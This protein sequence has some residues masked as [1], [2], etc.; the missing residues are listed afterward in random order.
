MKEIKFHEGGMPLNIDDLKLLQENS[1]ATMAAFLKVFAKEKECF[2][3]HRLSATPQ[4][5]S[6]LEAKFIAG[7]LVFNGMFLEI[8]ETTLKV[9]SWQDKIY[10]CV[11]EVEKDERIFEDGQ[12][13]NCRIERQA[14]LSTEKSEALSFD[15]SKLST[16]DELFVE[17]LNL[18]RFEPNWTPIP[19]FFFNGYS[20]KIML[21]RREGST[22]IK[23]QITSSASSW[24][25]GQEGL[26]FE[27]GGNVSVDPIGLGFLDRTCS[28]VFA[29]AGDDVPE[30]AVLRYSDYKCRVEFLKKDTSAVLT[31]N[32][33]SQCSINIIYDLLEQ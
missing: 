24:T 3:L 4:N 5:N 33:P 19:V 14:Y 29:T 31:Q 7:V 30:I 18:K 11:K 1:F 6:L 22:R 12:A 32:S 21:Q 26:L 27:L 9:N 15:T 16:F 20:G 8:P 23:I 10:I 25:E 2:L 17:Y 28:K 13:K